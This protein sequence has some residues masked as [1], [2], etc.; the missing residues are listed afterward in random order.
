M[1]IVR[2]MSQMGKAEVTEAVII[3][4]G[5][6]SRLSA[7][8]PSKPLTPVC[9]LP[10]VGI[11]AR[12]LAAAKVRRI[13]V[14][15]GHMA[16]RVEAALPAIARDC[17]LAIDAVRIDDWTVPNGHSVMAGAAA[18]QGNYL[19]VMADHI[20]SGSILGDLGRCH[21]PRFAVTLAVDRRIDGPMIDP[22]DATYVRT[23]ADGRIRAIG[24]RLPAAD[25]VDCGAFLATPRLAEAIAAAIALG[26]PGS[27]SDGMQWLA[28]RG[29][30]AT[31]D[32]GQ[33]WWI[34]VD[35]PASHQQAERD[36][37]RHLPHLSVAATGRPSR[38]AAPSQLEAPAQA[39]DNV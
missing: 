27:L 18:V 35:D 19:L 24:K 34:D 10:L 37:F 11:A 3:A 26:R 6:G 29:L 13:V 20:L 2:P 36:L 7:L 15:T 17:D 31:M 16:G 8:G 14:V 23:A 30:A 32:I 38:P 21:D 12:Q 5:F 28:E 25:A 22:E 33:Q 9:G 4:A 1:T 39:W